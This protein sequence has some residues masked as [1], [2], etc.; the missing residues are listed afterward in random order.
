[1]QV[2]IKDDHYLVIMNH[3]VTISRVQPLEKF[4]EYLQD[5]YKEFDSKLTT[6]LFQIIRETPDGA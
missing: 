5:I 2:E 4:K 6:K 3:V 1:M